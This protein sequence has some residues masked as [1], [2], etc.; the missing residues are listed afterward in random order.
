MNEL[1]YLF[2]IVKYYFI[3]LVLDYYDD[4]ITS[5]SDSVTYVS[6]S[7][8]QASA[9]R[10]S[11]TKNRPSIK[12]ILSIIFYCCYSNKLYVFYL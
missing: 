10:I 11:I 4:D 2:M 7:T 6:K 9:S 12:I 5:S 1:N 3:K 8:E